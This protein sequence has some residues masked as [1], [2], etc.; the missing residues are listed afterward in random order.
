MGALVAQPTAH[1]VSVEI[2]RFHTST[3]MGCRFHGSKNPRCYLT[4]LAGQ[5]ARLV[6]SNRH[7]LWLPYAIGGLTMDREFLK[8]FIT[9]TNPL[10]P[11]EAPNPNIDPELHNA[12]FDENNEIFKLLNHGRTAIV[13]RKG[14]G[15]TSLLYSSL[16]TEPNNITVLLEG[17]DLRG[18]FKSI[19]SSINDL[20]ADTALVEQVGNIWEFLF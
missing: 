20:A 19:I 7:N 14:S 13:G 8:K 12:F 5:P 6:E 10:G 11:I 9:E 3:G 15:K 17:A 18:L 1:G 2:G 16:I 4:S